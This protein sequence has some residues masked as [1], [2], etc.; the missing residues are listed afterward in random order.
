MLISADLNHSRSYALT[1]RGKQRVRDAKA[2]RPMHAACQ[3]G[4]A[5]G[6]DADLPSVDQG[7]SRVSALK[8]N[9]NG[10]GCTRSLQG[11]A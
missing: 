4:G 9:L 8:S 6:H 3:Q 1:V 7:M 2:D 5:D 10:A 11:L